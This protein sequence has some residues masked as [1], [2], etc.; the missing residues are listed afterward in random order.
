MNDTPTH[1]DAALLQRLRAANLRPTIARISV[2]QLLAAKA[3]ELL[4]AETLYRALFERGLNL[5]Q[6][7]LYRAL[8]ELASHGLLAREWRHGHRGAKA[9]YG[10]AGHR[11]APSPDEDRITCRH[12]GSAVPL[13]DPALLARLR[14]VALNQGLD[15]AGRP[16]TIVAMCAHCALHEAAAGPGVLHEGHG[17]GGPGPFARH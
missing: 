16:M 2:L 12:C 3:P 1:A 13:T 11:Q 8:N 9:V 15:L 7:T 4:D 14:R 17:T 6:G 10:I 5:S